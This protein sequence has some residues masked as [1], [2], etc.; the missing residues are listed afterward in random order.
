MAFKG[1]F[2]RKLERYYL[3]P[4]IFKLNMQV[5]I[6]EKFVLLDE[7]VIA[8][9]FKQAERKAIEKIKEHIEIKSVG[10]RVLGKTQKFN[11]I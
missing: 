1:S 9:N 6:Y 5:R 4:R 3:Q 11:S 7:I 2:T 8:H 10:Y